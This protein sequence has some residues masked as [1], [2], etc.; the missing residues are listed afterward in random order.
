MHPGRIFLAAVFSFLSMLVSGQTRGSHPDLG[1][2]G[3]LTWLSDSKVRI[4]Y[5]W[6]DDSQLL[7]WSTT[8]GSRLIRSNGT[9]TIS[10]GLADVRSMILKQLMRTTRIYVRDAVALNA[11]VAHLNF[12]TNVLGWT[13]YSF[14]PSGMIGLIYASNGNYFLTDGNTTALNA[15]DLVVNTPYSVDLAISNTQIASVSSADNKL[16]SMNLPFAPFKESQVA[17]GGYGGD[18]KWGELTIEG[19]IAAQLNVPA[20]MIDIAS[21]G[22]SFS[23][24]IEVTGNPVVEW[25]FGDSTLSS[26]VDPAK[27]YAN[28]G[29]HH[30]YLRVTPWSSLTGLNL[31]YD[32]A[33]DGYG[34]YTKMPQQNVISIRN[35]VWAG[36][37]LQY[38]CASHNPIT[39]LDLTGMSAIKIIELLECKNLTNLQLG[40]HPFLER[41]CVE[42]NN[43]STLNLSGCPNLGDLRAASNLYSYISWGQAG[44]KLWHICVRDN[45]IL[46]TSINDMTKF[47]L[48]KEL[49]TWN[50]NQSGILICHSTLVQTIDSYA[51]HY[52][53][54]DL[55][56]CDKL[57]RLTLSESKL[58]TLNI[59]QTGTLTNLQLKDCGLTVSLAD[60]V[61]G[62]LDKAGKTGGSLDLT[63]NCIPSTEGMVSYNNLLGKGWTIKMPVAVSSIRISTEDG[64]YII[65]EGKKTFQLSAKVLPG[66]ASD[67]TVSW[68]IL[69]GSGIATISETGLITALAAGT[70][71]IKASSN[72]GSGV[73]STI[74]IRIERPESLIIT[75]KDDILSVRVTN[76]LISAKISLL[77]LYGRTIETKTVES[78][79]VTFNIASL[80]PGMYLLNAYKKVTITTGKFLKPY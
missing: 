14:N 39:D 46:T 59:D 30:N 74:D 55:S 33:D 73:F 79:L 19:E 64:T 67:T 52:S 26:S 36:G 69:N 54:A 47:P 34:G 53:G 80:P 25:V 44:P 9:V 76:N 68:S 57:E 72:D 6:S 12:I 65:R 42:N 66:S 51:N 56:G 13:G 27:N 17:V 22:N 8:E 50:D 71:T 15:P 41:L 60:Y 31:G 32:A 24:I 29:V 16:Y 40:S 61:L 18:T 70:I 21:I 35:L 75:L 11:S 62:T 38:L 58:T 37:S 20:D 23:P 49:L 63:G 48:L 7:D 4:V 77:N 43:L 28:D 78:N 5:D 10:G 45:P 2:H 1:L 3:Q